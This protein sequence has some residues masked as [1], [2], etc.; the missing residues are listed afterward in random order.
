VLKV[1]QPGTQVSAVSAEEAAK[2]QR[3][4]PRKEA[5]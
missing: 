5:A 4:P 3:E 2:P 1:F